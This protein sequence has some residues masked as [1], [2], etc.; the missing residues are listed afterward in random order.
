M[1]TLKK[2]IKAIK[3]QMFTNIMKSYDTPQQCLSKH[4]SIPLRRHMF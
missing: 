2:R 4:A 3:S 1:L